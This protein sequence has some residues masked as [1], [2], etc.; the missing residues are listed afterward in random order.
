MRVLVAGS[1]AGW[2]AEVRP[3]QILDF[4]GGAFLR[5]NSRR[6]VAAI[7]GHS[8]MLAL[9]DVS[10]LFVVKRFDVPLD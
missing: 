3:V 5:T 1:A 10:R 6:H 2:Q 8:R 7:A 9:K 4:D